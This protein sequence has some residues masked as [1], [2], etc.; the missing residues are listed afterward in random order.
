MPPSRVKTDLAERTLALILMAALLCAPAAFRP[1]D[2]RADDGAA[3]KSVATRYGMTVTGGN[4]YTPENDISFVLLSGFALFDYGRLWG[5]RAP[6][7]LRFKVEGSLGATT[8][9]DQKLMTST[10]IFALYYLNGLAS[11]TFRPASLA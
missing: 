2:V 7:A 4:S 11:G 6:D 5:L 3:A 8:R 10:N 1:G 9:P